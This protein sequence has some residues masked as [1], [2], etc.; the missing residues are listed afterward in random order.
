MRSFQS[1]VLFLA[2]LLLYSVQPG[3]AEVRLPHILSSNMVLQR[4]LE[5]KVWG[6]ADSKEKVTVHFNDVTISTKADKKGKWIL[7]LPAMKAGGPFNMKIRGKN[8]IE[9]ENIL[10]GDVWI[11]SG[12]SNMDWDVERSDNAEDEAA[13]AEYTG[14]R[15]FNISNNIQIEP[16]DDIPDGEWLECNSET[17]LPFS[18]VGYFFGREIHKEMNVPVGL[19]STNW[20]GTTIETWTSLEAIRTVPYFAEKVEVLSG[21]DFEK[22]TEKR[23]T[24]LKE[25]IDKYAADEPGIQDGQAI[26]ADPE[27]DMEEWGTMELPGRWEDCGLVGLDGIVWFRFEFELSAEAMA[28]GITINM[29]AIDD[30]DQTWVNG[31]KVGEMI[32]QY[33]SPRIYKAAPEYLKEGKNVIAVRVEDTG[34]GGGFH[35]KAE[36]MELVFGGG[37]ISLAGD[38]NYRVSP[39]KL[40]FSEGDITDPDDYPTLLFNGMIH[41]VLNYPITGA[42]WYQGESNVERAYQYR[43]LMPLMIEDWRTQWDQPD[44]PF[45]IVQLANYKTPPTQPEESNWAELRE[46]QS[47]ALSFPNTGMAVAI[48]IGEASDIHPTNKQDV[49]KRLALSAL[50]VAYGRDIVYSGPVFR[51]MNNDSSH[52][53]LSFDHIGSGL[54]C[55]DRYGYVK[56]FAIAG[57][58]S[59]F[60]WA[61]AHIKGD[62]VWVYSDKVKEPVAVRYGWANNPDDVNLYNEEGLPASPFRTDDWPGITLDNK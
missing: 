4:N 19:I 50:K 60:H 42:I 13:N 32:Q 33:N 26:W 10:I 34:G 58:D 24:G 46:A 61:K 43:T 15:L 1:T 11:C 2:I 48:D 45:F 27:L 41:P 17:V 21:F 8:I 30:S 16:A 56:G 54:L 51:E 9:L 14:I 5:I 57:S 29:G 7:T 31:N 62:R 25:L 52:A 22:I 39:L 36:D 23:K 37:K 49:G 40:K 55:K 44:F 12:Q 18:A 28:Q 38:W 47:M 53:I 6:W 3:L 35:G 59:V 20:G